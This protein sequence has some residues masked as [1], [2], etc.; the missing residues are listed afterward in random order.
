MAEIKVKYIID[1]DIMSDKEYEE[2]ET[3]EFT[4]TEQMI[5]EFV[6]ANDSKIV[7]LQDDIQ[8][9]EIELT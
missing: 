1:N 6:M 9:E 3:K 2:Q 5:K 7:H 4:I 8:I